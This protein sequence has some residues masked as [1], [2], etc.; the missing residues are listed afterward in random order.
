MNIEVYASYEYTISVS[1][2]EGYKTPDPI[3]YMADGSNISIN[4]QY[5]TEVVK[6]TA[7][8]EGGSSASGCILTIDGK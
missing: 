5:L 4:M 1:D 8:V 6:I 7:T 2:I 3:T